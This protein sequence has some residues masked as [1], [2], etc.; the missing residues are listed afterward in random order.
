MI[1]NM[2]F[3]IDLKIFLFLLLFYF[4]KQIEIYAMIMFFAIIHEFGHLAAGLLLGMKPQKLE[5]MPFGVSISFKLSPKD[6]NQKI[7]NGNK[8]ELKK[9][10]VAISGPLTNL[11]IILIALQ[12]KFN[13]FFMLMI[14]YSNLLLIL[15]NLL[16]IFPLDGGRVLKGILHIFFGRTK[17]EKYINKISFVSLIIFTFVSSI[18]IYKAENFAILLIIFVLWAI[19]IREDIVYKRRIKIYNMIQ[20]N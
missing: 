15:F 7:K 8:L 18:A 4:T 13:V 9:I 6:Y 19:F 20:E 17:A 10:L 14:M 1:R 12:F 2:R 11:I 5:I 16:P 3:R